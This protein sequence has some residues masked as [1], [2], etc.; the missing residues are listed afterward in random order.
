MDPVLAVAVLT[1]TLAPAV[2]SLVR[3]WL[4]ARRLETGQ[5]IRLQINGESI[6]L[7]PSSPEELKDLLAALDR[8]STADERDQG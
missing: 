7:D 3:K 5:R 6:E 8:D 4:S 2:S 1:G